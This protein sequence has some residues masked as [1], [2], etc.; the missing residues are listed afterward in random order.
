MATPQADI[1]A[2]PDR[3]DE[4]EKPAPK[5]RG[6]PPKAQAA[7]EAKA[8]PAKAAKPPKDDYTPEIQA[9]VSSAWFVAA[10][11]PQTQAYALVLSNSSD[12][13][14]AALNEGAK[15]NDTIRRFVDGGGE[16]MWAVQL[17]AVAAQMGLQAYQ[18]SKSP[19]MRKA[20]AEAT[21]SQLSEM[22]AQVQEQAADP[23][24]SVALW[25]S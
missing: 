7:P 21:K 2:P 17:A 24:P 4:P 6:R 5:R 10:S 13:L 1:P 14:V 23:E 18:L 22:I 20:A 3:K 8:K 15:K 19:E 9:V 12:A 16:S 11:I 25:R